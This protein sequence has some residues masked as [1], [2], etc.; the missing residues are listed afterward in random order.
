MVNKI[1]KRLVVCL[2]MLSTCFTMSAQVFDAVPARHVLGTTGGSKV[3][4]GWGSIDYTV[5]EVFVT[6]ESSS[7]TSSPVNWLTQGFQQPD[8]AIPL[9]IP[10]EVPLTIYHGFTP[11]DDQHND[12]WIID[13]IENIPKNTVS[14]FNRWG[15][16][17][18]KIDDYNNLSPNVWD[19]KNT[20]GAK[21]P[22]ATYFYIIEANE[23]LEKG[24]VEL[25]R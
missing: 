1:L 7:S 25:T 18:W 9:A 12:T 23:I 22:D 13:G 17:V 19:G 4:P 14:I 5:G 16:R 8:D 6:T 20:K 2:L 3:I 15:D 11:N 10:I 24:W 21:L